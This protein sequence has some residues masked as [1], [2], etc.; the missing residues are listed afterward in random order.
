[1]GTGCCQLKD[2]GAIHG[3]FMGFKEFLSTLQLFA[4]GL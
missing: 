2:A 4:L 1:M 3:V